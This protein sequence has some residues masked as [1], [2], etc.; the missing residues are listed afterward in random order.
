M[1]RF[2]IYMTASTVHF[3]SARLTMHLTDQFDWLSFTAACS[4]IFVGIGFGGVALFGS[5]EGRDG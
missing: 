3:M 2:A 5:K 1:T 4:M